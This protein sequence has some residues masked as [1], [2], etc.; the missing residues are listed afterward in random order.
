MKPWGT[1]NDYVG[2]LD[3]RKSTFGSV[4]MLGTGVVLWSSKKQ[5]I[6]TLPSQI[7]LRKILEEL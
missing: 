1:D 7:W 3:D 5:P 2:D 4:F 6:V